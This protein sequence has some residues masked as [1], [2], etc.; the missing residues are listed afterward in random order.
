MIRSLTIIGLIRLAVACFCAF[1]T[2]G[3]IAH[4]QSRDASDAS[5]MVEAPAEVFV[6]EV[7]QLRVVLRGTTATTPP[8]MPEIPNASIEYRG[9]ST[10]TGMTIIIN[11][12]VQSSGGEVGHMYA[13]MARRP[14]EIVV[15]S[16]TI[17]IGGRTLRSSPVTIKVREVPKAPD[18]TLTVKGPEGPVY[19]GQPVPILMEWR[20]GRNVSA[21]A[22]TLPI[23]G[24]A[25]EVYPDSRIAT[26]P[27]ST[28]A[29][30]MVDGDR[31]AV[32]FSS[33]VITAERIIIP[34][35]PGVITVGPARVDFGAAAGQRAPNIMDLPG[36]D[37]TVYER[38][39]CEAQPLRISVIDLPVEGRPQQF[40]GLVGSYSIST[41]ADVT[42]LSVGDPITLTVTV[43][44]PAPLSRVPAL[45]LARQMSGAAEFRIP[46]EPVLPQ[47]TGASA[48]F[49]LVIRPRSAAV[50]QVGPVSL[51]SFD[52]ISRSYRIAQ[53]APIKLTVAPSQSVALPGDDT[54]SAGARQTTPDADET[55]RKS[56]V[57]MHPP[58][59]GL[60]DLSFSKE[61]PS[62]RWVLAGVLAGPPLMF[63]ALECL[64]LVQ[65]G[66][67]RDPA[68][69]RRKR[70]LSALRRELR[71]STCPSRALT[72]FVADWFDA[73][74]E[75]LTAREA[76]ALLHSCD[77][78]SVPALADALL[79]ADEPR[80]APAA[81][82]A[83]SPSSAR[84]LEIASGFARSHHAR[85]VS[86]AGM[87]G[88]VLVGG[89]LI[90]GLLSV[91][92]AARAQ[93]VMPIGS[94]WETLARELDAALQAAETGRAVSNDAIRSLG[95]RFEAAA[96]SST[97]ARLRAAAFYNAGIAHHRVGDLAAAMLNFRR[98]DLIAPALPGLA[99]R[100]SATRAQVLGDASATTSR[101]PHQR[102]SVPWTRH[103]EAVLVSLPEGALTV[104]ACAAWASLWLAGCLRLLTSRIRVGMVVI[105]LGVLCVL[106]SAIIAHRWYREHAAHFHA[107]LIVETTPRDHPDELIGQ[108]SGSALRAGHEVRI[109]TSTV[110]GDGR[111]WCEIRSD[112]RSDEPGERAWWLPHDAL[113]RIADTTPRRVTPAGS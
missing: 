94:D 98:A 7:H 43:T 9:V 106:T 107:V 81:Q 27:S 91:M 97:T 69:R 13:L 111:V 36:S 87:R 45:D 12:Q 53:S 33:G 24:S 71:A 32:L 28:Q 60:G 59:P 109:V 110:G 6:G 92:P 90:A 88:R 15:P 55:E 50:T 105:V 77:H 89:L 25:H 86:G 30:M 85:H 72:H 35:E 48:T 102:T 14:G 62:T 65:W 74:R 34:T 38:L 40:S 29:Q 41:S 56:G 70:A 82:S 31:T 68:K 5:I 64:R 96:S 52:P 76:V 8:T 101:T 67:R 95:D 16:M 17:D 104:V 18:F 26:A 51:S 22:A 93:A 4:A 21:P 11:G 58:R 99:E 49:K 37:R 19:V 113:R 73:P 23:S 54:L 42:S 103:A 75:S 44:G 112:G 47:I 79:N 57:I 83:L 2:F 3:R 80:F 61:D 1:S 100:L 78:P 10:S 66:A 46:R 39:F 63:V 20:L 84:I 108:P